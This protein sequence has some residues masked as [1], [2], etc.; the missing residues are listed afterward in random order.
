MNELNSKMN[1]YLK[2][3]DQ[4]NP[5]RSTKLSML[6]TKSSNLR[7][8]R[9]LSIQKS[10]QFQDRKYTSSPPVKEK[11]VVIPAIPNYPITPKRFKVEETNNESLD[12][13]SK[14]DTT[15]VND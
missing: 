8:N 1:E 14:S 11:K 7:L 9:H 2:N 13:S 3:E 6:M 5:L 15:L 12:E 4:P 10:L